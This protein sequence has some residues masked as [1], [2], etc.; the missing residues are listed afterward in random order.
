MV[1]SDRD[2]FFEAENFVKMREFSG[3]E[4]TNF[5][6][7]VRREKEGNKQIC[8]IQKLFVEG[9]GVERILDNF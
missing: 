1:I 5:R 6:L 9:L 8:G 7:N 2:G 3:S 4:A